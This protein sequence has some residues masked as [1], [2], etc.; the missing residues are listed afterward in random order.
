VATLSQGCERGVIGYRL[1]R[2]FYSD[3]FS[4]GI[5]NIAVDSQSGFNSPIVVR[6]AKLKD[7]PWNGWLRVGMASEAKAAWNPVAGFTDAVGRLCGRRWATM[8][9]CPSPTTAAGCRTAPRSCPTTMSASRA[10]RSSC[11][12]TR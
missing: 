1:A 9:I 11:R 6:T 2:E 12:P 3:D 7:F 5:E 4:N 8:P 10:G